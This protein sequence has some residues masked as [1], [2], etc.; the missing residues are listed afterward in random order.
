[1]SNGTWQG[2]QWHAEL[3]QIAVGNHWLDGAGNVVS[4]DDGR[5]ALAQDL[6]SG[7]TLTMRLVVNA[8][9]QPGEYVLEV[10][11]VQE[12][13]SWFGLKGSTTWR[14]RVKGN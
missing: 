1:M 12:G 11:V 4:N 2:R 13:V 3:F 9:A 14:G 6:R 10:D 5:T 8:P 7:E